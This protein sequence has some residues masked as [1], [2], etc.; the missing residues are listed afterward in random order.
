MVRRYVLKNKLVIY[1]LSALLVVMASFGVYSILSSYFSLSNI[2]DNQWDGVSVS[3]SFSS[4]NGSLENPYVINNGEDLAF[5]KKVIEGLNFD[6]YSDK[7]YVL[8]SDI[9]LGDNEF[10]SIGIVD[11]EVEKLF[12][13]HFDGNGYTIKNVKLVGNEIDSYEMYG[14]FTILDG[15][16]VSNINLENF[17]IYPS[18]SNNPY[19]IGTLAA[20]VRTLSNI[21][22]I[23]IYNGTINLN[24]SL[25]N[26]SS[27]IAG[28]VGRVSNEVSINNVY[29]NTTLNSDYSNGVAKVSH[30]IDSDLSNVVVNINANSL[31]TDVASYY[32]ASSNN[33][34]INN[35]YVAV[36]DGNDLKITNN[37]K[38]VANDVIVT[39]FDESITGDYFW[40][41]EDGTLKLFRVMVQEEVMIPTNFAFGSDV[42]V[43]HDTGIDATNGIVYINDLSSDLN[44]FKGLNYTKG[45]DS[46]NVP[47]GI[48]KNKYN[49][50]NLVKVFMQYNG[51]DPDSENAIGHVS[52]SE[53]FSKFNY[54]KYYY[55]ENGYITIELIDNPFADR[56]NDKTFG[57]WVTSYSGVVITYDKDTHTYY[58]KV[59]VS[60]VSKT[61]NIIFNVRWVPGSIYT[62]G[63]SDWDT[64]L[65]NL[66]ERGFVEIEADYIVS[67]DV[68]VLY[69][70]KSIGR[71][72]RL[73]R[74]YYDTNGV[75]HNDSSSVRCSQSSIMVNNTCEYY[76]LNGDVDYDS[77]VT[78]Y[79]Y[80]NGSMV[81][82]VLTTIVD[83][84][85]KIVEGGS[86]AGYYVQKTVPYNSTYTGYYDSTG[87]YMESGRCTTSSGCTYYE[88]LQYTDSN[89]NPNI[90]DGENNKY[91]WYVTR[92]TNVV[93]LTANNS[94]SF[95]TSSYNNRPF[96]ITGLNK[97][98]TYNVRYTFYNTYI[99]LK[100]DL[101]IEHV[102]LSS[103]QS[104]SGGGQPSYST[105][106]SGTIY[107]NFYNLK[108][109][110]GITKYNSYQSADSIIGGTNGTN[111][112]SSSAPA[113]Y[114]L[115]IESGFYND[116]GVVSGYGSYRTQR[117]V[118]TYANAIYGN[119]FDRANNNNSLLGIYNTAAGA[120][121]D[122][123]YSGTTSRVSTEIAI[124]TIVKSGGFGTGRYDYTSG[125]YVGGL[126]SGT[127]YAARR[128]TVEGGEIYNINGGPLTYDGRG[129]VN[130]IYINIKGGTTEFVF[131]GA[132]RSATYGNRIIQVT[133]GVV[134][135]GVFG[136]SNSYST[137]S[138]GD[139]VLNGTPFIYI[140]GNATIGTSEAINAGEQYGEIVGSVYGIGN[141]N[142]RVTNAGTA[143][144]STII[145]D[146]AAIINGSVF[147]GGNYG[148]VGTSNNAATNTKIKILGGTI[149]GSVYGGGNNNGAGTQNYS[150]DI[151]IDMTGGTVGNIYGGSR[152]KG[153]VYGNS[154]VNVLGGVVT[155]DVYG[156]G[157][158]GYT[159]SNSPGT[160][161][162]ENVSVKIGQSINDEEPKLTINGNVYGG[163]AYGTVNG[164]T[165]NGSAVTNLKTTVDV[166][167]GVISKS[168]FGGGKGNTTFTPKIYGPVTVNIHGGNIGNVYGGNDAA[169]QP[170]STDNVYLDGGT[171]GNAFGG[172]NSTGQTTT[173]VFLRGATVGN[174]FG[175]SNVDGIVT[176][177]KVTMSGGRVT[178]IYGG[179][180]EG[181]STTDTVVNI[182][183][184]TVDGDIYGGGLMAPVIN[185]TSVTITDL[186]VNNVYGGGQEA[187]AY[188]T[189]VNITGTEGKKVF[190]GSNMKGTVNTSNVEINGN[191][192]DAI[193]GGN[194]AGGVTNSSN[195]SINAGVIGVVYGGGD[196]AETGI[197]KVEILSGTITDVFG[198]G[199]SAGLESS[200]VDVFGGTVNNIYG[201]SNTTGDVLSTDVS[202]G[203]VASSPTVIS[204]YGG[205]NL[206]GVTGNTNVLV[207]KGNITDIYG[208]GNEAVSG[209]TK[210]EVMNATVA[211]IFGGG[212]RAAVTGSTYLDIDDCILQTDVYG[213]GNE[214]S[215]SGTTEVFVTDSSITGSLFG[216]GKGSSAVV[217]GNSTVNVD[218]NTVVGS[219]TSK[220]PQQGCV[221]G[222]GKLANTGSVD[223]NSMVT[224]NIVGG[225]I[226]G[227]VYGG[228]NTAIVYGGTAINVG[229]AAVS[230][231]D[232]VQSDII[233]GGTLFG[234]GETNAEGSDDY[235]FEFFSVIG[236]IKIYIDGSGYIENN[237]K[238]TISGSI[239]GSGNASNSSGTSEIYIKKLGTK[240]VVSRNISVQRTQELTIDNSY[241]EFKG[242]QDRT[243]E[244]ESE[245]Y[246]FNFVDKLIVK[247]N[248][249]LYLRETTNMLLE[250]YSGVDVDGNLVPAVVEINDETKKITRNVDNRIFTLPL[251]SFHV[252]KDEHATTYGRVTGMTF[253]GMY[254]SDN[255]GVIYTGVYDDSYQYGD[256]ATE[257]DLLD[258][259]AY[260]L[261]LHHDNHDITADGFYTNVLNEEETAV[262]TE[263]ITPTPPAA[264]HYRWA[265][266]LE[267]IN[268]D[269][270]LTA[271]KY[272]SL[273]T[274]N[275]SMLEFPN[276]D[277]TFNITGFN[278]GGLETG[279]RLI[280]PSD[281]PRLADDIET[282]NTTFGLAMKSE[283]REWTSYNTTEFTGDSGGTYIGD[284]IYK[285]DSQSVIPSLKFYL[286]HPKNITY[287]GDIGKVV[288]M[289][290]AAERIS[291][292][293][294]KYSYVSIVVNMVARNYDD[295]NSYDASIT[296]DKKYEMPSATTVNITNQSQFTAYYALY[297]SGTLKEIYGDN[298]E[299]YHV[300]TSTYALPVG[301][302]ITMIDYGQNIDNP[303]YYYY[304]ITQDIYN[305]SVS[306]LENLGEIT[307]KISDFIKMGSTSSDNTY[308][309]MAANMAYYDDGVSMAMEEFIFIFDFKD[310]T[311]TG[312]HLGNEIL[313]ELRD[314][315]DMEIV[316]VLGIRRQLMQYGLYDSSNVVLQEKMESES[317]YLY[318]NVENKLNFQSGVA[319]EQTSDGASVIDTN[320]ESSA[321]GL[322]MYVYDNSGNQVSSSLLSG[323]VLYVDDQ[324][325][326]ADGD[327]VF[328]VKLAGK[329]SN[330]SKTMTLLVD[331]VLP[332]GK[333]KLRFVLFASADGK[334]NSSLKESAIVEINVTVVGDDNAI[335][336]T[337]DDKTKVVDGDTGLNQLDTRVNKYV[338]NYLS[339]LENPNVRVHLYKRE[340]AD[341]Y[342][343]EYVEVDFNSLFTN[344]LNSSSYASSYLYEKV[345]PAGINTENIYE[346][347]LQENLVSGTY[348]LVFKLYDGIHLIEE[349][350]EYVIVT[351]DV[352]NGS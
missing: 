200:D 139:G 50:S 54:Y 242:I 19:M 298:Y 147:G 309:E 9:D 288:I 137:T 27:K 175:G 241:I 279:I 263:Y 38:S 173:N 58:A 196:K 125:I 61:I 75:Y 140:G 166:Y 252:T 90:V 55:V 172:G 218:G 338:L 311:T 117:N 302:Q 160:F 130:D 14:L 33:S 275:L 202:V 247:N 327:G 214:G 343:T 347:E 281:V 243:N 350:N 194:N 153:I 120:W 128:L 294:Y 184:G 8:G 17:D 352:V 195:V 267:T 134:T 210:V 28:F 37:G 89:G 43:E 76:E 310:T 146:G 73:P 68:S 1:V 266:G 163:S 215:V 40:G 119:D 303:Q 93:V 94:T 118:Y 248:T 341:K 56:P 220:I 152:T 155:A 322:N 126:N 295:G 69:V 83:F 274:F 46:N 101:R 270:T 39:D 314:N 7:Y 20:E 229:N 320:Y 108:I 12:K 315:D 213:G 297:A 29:L 276:G 15:A 304:N 111:S 323:T 171:I 51:A 87:T 70:F 258:G 226:Y 264:G 330:L 278:S 221:F 292:I 280:D 157:E 331:K 344:S 79:E 230:N 300:L 251:S 211:N 284:S 224:V 4:G 312:Q 328:R 124:D 86:A 91:Y 342:S 47:D 62:L 159:N 324:A 149:V 98:Q 64:A 100:E 283:T 88:L 286:Y 325:N 41:I 260:A 65:S 164:S 2:V 167:Y 282:A 256:A 181:T 63:S 272:S 188:S 80:V 151:T 261:G 319:Y 16:T 18:Q 179:N 233:I 326:F 132:G 212:N 291:A 141:G 31:I 162:T 99:S 351:K 232:L 183:G 158:G 52:N 239:F 112:T 148:A 109:G 66:D 349:E 95:R 255:N 287:E 107:G 253:F 228:A 102:S 84:N 339:V 222:S 334:H 231:D 82:K 332:P 316:T 57:G 115:I 219:P 345:L 236:S 53:Q 217:Y 237:N 25:E 227:N 135:N 35:L 96:T 138:S 207:N 182:S 110:R 234:G 21:K 145:I 307:Y 121:G 168:V 42:L 85:G 335:L 296:Y 156:G 206:G 191:K 186:K 116:I 197:S 113:K 71:N 306:Q 250:Y 133:D 290:E 161:V 318:Y 340:T 198:G 129:S 123:I 32:A 254:T 122:Y 346:F 299:N 308:D 34:T 244:Y 268:Y 240:D 6:T 11:G 205:N 185:S 192:F 105:T 3:S 199:N 187:D 67:D 176:S 201:G 24:S 144:A 77:S 285:T 170:A 154:N 177:A 150:C 193:Y 305:N 104:T 45:D 59:P 103:Q 293:E 209:S 127:H 321:M 165:N 204:I 259:G 174:L 60:D 72:S 26:T 317:N 92:D 245:K 246:T 13:G 313:F 265:V 169:G 106:G 180:N 337:T 74:Q 329:V 269:I 114:K 257:E 190:G 22:N 262:I 336:V 273:G 36:K 142:S 178:N 30:T 136:G 189:S 225:H 249:R 44:H 301:T 23:S 143:K 10:T 5:F 271:S 48:N 235:N 223:T 208:G 78:Y 97:D 216:G 289:M 238:F 348:K 277:T 131:G 203:S 49:S 81:E 333:Y